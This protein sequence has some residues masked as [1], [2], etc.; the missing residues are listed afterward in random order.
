MPETPLRGG[1]ARQEEL[2]SAVLDVL[3]EVGYNRLTVDAVVARARA[4]KTTVYRRWPSKSALVIAAFTEATKAIPTKPNTGS[5]RGDLLAIL[6]A[7]VIE[8]GSFGDVVAGLVSEVQHNPDLASAMRDTFVQH[9]KQ[10]MLDI[11]AAA[12]ERG[13]IPV[14]TDFDLL[15]HLGPALLFFRMLF[16]GEQVDTALVRRLVDGVV[17]PAARAGAHP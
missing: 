16:L 10:A 14:D 7:L 4:S 11:L 9:R 15:W 6:D 13:E 3:R 8:I 17:L 1:P 5:L 2:L 12:R